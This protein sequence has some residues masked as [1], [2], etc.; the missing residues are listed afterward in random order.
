LGVGCGGE[1]GLGSGRLAHGEAL[2]AP[3]WLK[4]VSESV[5]Q[6]WLHEARNFMTSF[7]NFYTLGEL[8]FFFFF[9]I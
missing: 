9:Q 6:V 8:L 2:R 1:L 5:T 3:L 7:E 4:K